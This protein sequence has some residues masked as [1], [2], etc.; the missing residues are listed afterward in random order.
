VDCGAGEDRLVSDES[1]ERLHPEDERALELLTSGTMDVLPHGG[2]AV[3]L[4]AARREGRAL[5][6]KL[7]IDPS[8]SD[9]TL[10][11][12]VVLRKLRQFQDTG[13]LAVLIVGDF[14]GMVGDPSD[15]KALRQS[16]TAEQTAQNSA[17][18][19][20]QVL[21]VLNPD[22]TELRRNSEWLAEMTMTDVV[23]E[24][25]HLTVAQLLEREDFA[26]RFAARQPISLVEFLYP[27]L[28]GYD[29]VAVGAD[30]ELGGTDQTYNLLVGRELQRAHGQPQQVVVT[31]P[32][33][34]G[35]DGR[36]KMSKSLGNYVAI[37]EPP[38]QQYGKLMSLRDDGLIGRYLSLCTDL[39]PAE[40]ELV[41]TQAAGGGP[42]AA[43]AK[44]RMARE[45]VA[46]YHGLDAAAAAEERFTTVFRQHQLPG[47]VPAAP[48]VDG[49]PVHLPRALVAAG[50][51]ATTSEARRLLRAGAVRLDNRPLSADALDVARAD[52]VGRVVA[53]GRRKMA[54]LVEPNAAG[55]ATRA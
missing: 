47:E 23:R 36:Q 30:V 26:R 8:G 54:R 49:D 11:H 51:A 38:D 44:R 20:E 41:E 3:R 39:P 18:Y 48:L 50:L 5:R 27:L 4:A 2:L 25:R 34:E 12:A 32:L 37:A 13:H 55:G 9:L 6:V 15:K 52:L 1:A 17:S 29:S 46:L 53:A 10:G 19:L 22:R 31:V 14:T 21:R 28:Q 35:L 24:A 16:L 40:I 42:E 7:G 43:A 33:L 45:V